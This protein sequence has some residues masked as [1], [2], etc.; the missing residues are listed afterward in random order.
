MNGASESHPR[1][2]QELDVTVYPHPERRYIC[3]Q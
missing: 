2:L 3:L 1:V